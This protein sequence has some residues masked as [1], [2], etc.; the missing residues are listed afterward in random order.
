MTDKPRILVVDDELGPRESL[1]MVFKPY[2]EVAMVE[3]GAAALEALP[4]FRPDVVFIDIKMPAMDGLE[5]LR[6]IK[7]HDPSV[8]VVMITAYASLE[9]V[10]SALTNGAFE[11]LIKPFSRH[12]LERTA[13]RA[14]ARRQMEVGA[15]GQVARLVEQ[16]RGLAAKTRELEEAARREAAEQSLRVTQLSILREISGGILSQLDLGPMTETITE[17]LKAG[18]GYDEVSI[19]LG[20]DPPAA[21]DTATCVVCPIRED[22]TILGHLVADNRPSACPIDPRE[23]ELLEML[24]EY[25]AIAIRNSRL[26]G[27]IAE[28]KRFLE[29]LIHSAGD[30]IVS[31]DREDRIVGWNPAAEEIF[32][33]TEGTMFGEPVTRILPAADYLRAKAALA[34]GRPA[35]HF[36]VR[37]RRPDGSRTELAVML[38]AF[39]ERGGEREGILAI[40]RDITT[41]RELEAQLLQSEKLTALGKLAGGIAH[42]FNNQLQAILGYAQLMARSPANTDLVRRGLEVIHTAATGGVETVK[43]IQQF[44]RL[45]PDEEFIPVDLNA[46]IREAVAIT[47]PRWD[48]VVGQRGI[49]TELRLDLAEIP[50][51]LGRPAALAEVVTNLILNAVEAMPSGGTLSITTRRQGP[52]RVAVV[53]ADTGVGMSE[54]VR[55][56]VFDPFFT[57]K[58]EAGTGLGL[59]ISYSIVTRHGG[60]IRVASQEGKGTTFTLLFPVRA[61]AVPEPPPVTAGQPDRTGRILVI[62][63]EPQVLGLLTEMLTAG[64]HRVTPAASGREALALFTPGCFDVVLTNIGMPGMTGWEVADRVR[65][66]DPHVPLAFIT[67][68]GL[69]A[70]DRERCRARGIRQCLFKPVQPD[71]LLQAIQQVMVK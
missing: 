18:L 2:Y 68:W 8:E 6:Q 31:V 60:E 23:R 14:L 44:A 41:Q 67:G 9:T 71:D 56:R 27:E 48:E 1:R 38:S 65:A 59:S 62:D 22:E 43:R 51:I 54:E 39:G 69:S 34:A 25:L 42:D 55:R 33:A 32:A 24:S 12:D 20:A 4:T 52:D 35:Q 66:A 19:H 58:G 53:I 28:T 47:R 21:A 16:M 26:Y 17:S 37:Q 29:Q 36:E 50:P 61:G 63:N 64:G 46:V 5:V 30:A 13:R 45:R 15:R 70:D 57:T 10:R 7:A 3:S 40:V 49:P 11:Y